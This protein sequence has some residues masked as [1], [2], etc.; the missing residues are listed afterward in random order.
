[1]KLELL[2]ELLTEEAIETKTAEDVWADGTVTTFIPT[3]IYSARKEDGKWAVYKEDGKR[4]LV[5]R[6]DSAAFEELYTPVRPNQKPDAEG[7]KTYRDNVELEAVKYDGDTI[8]VDTGA[9]TK[10]L[11]KGNYLVRQEGEDNFSYVVR[12][13]KYFES[14]YE[15]KE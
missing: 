10:K 13:A 5:D 3:T 7:F 12:D 15:V 11:R 1:M 4:K 8:K 14:D 2:S 9:G 6:F